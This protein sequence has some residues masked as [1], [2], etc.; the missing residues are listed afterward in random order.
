M[1]IQVRLT[2]DLE[3]RLSE[4]QKKVKDETGFEITITKLVH[5]LIEKGLAS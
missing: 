3:T 2:A 4:H 5:N 1:P